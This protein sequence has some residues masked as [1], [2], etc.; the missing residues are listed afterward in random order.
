MLVADYDP[1]GHTLAAREMTLYS[2]MANQI[3]GALESALLAQEAA[4]AVRLDEELRVARDIQTARLPASPPQLAGWQLAADW[5]SARLVG[6]DFYDFWRLPRAAA[7]GGWEFGSG[8]SNSR[9]SPKP[10][11]LG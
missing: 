1:P 10:Q 3:A 8:A 4:D 9:P 6:G 7:V 11:P 2:G 5:R